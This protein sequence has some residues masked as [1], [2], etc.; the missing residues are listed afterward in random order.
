MI[1]RFFV[2]SVLSRA[3]C[4]SFD[5]ATNAIKRLVGD[6]L[7]SRVSQIWGVNEE[8]EQY[9]AWR[10]L[11]V[12]NLWFMTGTHISVYVNGWHCSYAVHR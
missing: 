6:E 12:P 3:S 9:G 10:Y 5:G 8:G 4:D 7:S 1:P 2:A 11:G